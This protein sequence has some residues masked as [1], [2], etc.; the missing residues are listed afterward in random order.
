MDAILLSQGNLTIICLKTVKKPE[1][2]GYFINVHFQSLNFAAE[3][4]TH[5]P[6]K[7]QPPCPN[8]DR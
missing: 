2:L 1:S 6:T 4:K 8:T 5:V 7:T 3:N